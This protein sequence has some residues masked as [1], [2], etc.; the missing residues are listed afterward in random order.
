[1][2]ANM[3]ESSVWDK[4]LALATVNVLQPVEKESLS[5]SLSEYINKKQLG[6]TLKELVQEDL[7]TREEGYYRTTYKGNR[8]TI[9]PKAR[10]L[11]DI[12]RMRHLLFVSRQRGGE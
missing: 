8:L 4:L 12:Q 9:S 10:N 6:S 1:M 3:G 7:I 5:N 11:R 2:A